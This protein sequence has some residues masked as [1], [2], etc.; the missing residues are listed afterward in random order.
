LRTAVEI[1]SLPD[2]GFLGL[3]LEQLA[4]A[5]AGHIVPDGKGSARIEAASTDSR[6][7]DRQRR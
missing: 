4:A 5:S 7:S 2:G 3:Q 1:E 6:W